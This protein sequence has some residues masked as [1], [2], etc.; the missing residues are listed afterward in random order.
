MAGSN[1]S[2]IGRQL[3]IT[4]TKN[5]GP[6]IRKGD[7]VLIDVDAKPAKGRYVITGPGRLVR[8]RGQ[9]LVHG[10]AVQINRAV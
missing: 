6:H 1:R 8:W 7:R 3:F 10:V 4:A 9:K 2:A 5:I